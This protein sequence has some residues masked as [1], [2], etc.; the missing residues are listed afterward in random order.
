MSIIKSF[1][2]G[3]GDMFYIFHDSDNLSIIDCCLTDDNR[4]RILKEIIK[5]NNKKGI[6]RF[7]S[8]HPDE[9]HIRGLEYLDDKIGIMNFYA[10]ANRAAKADT[11][12]SFKRYCMLRDHNEKSFKIHNSC[13]RKW[14]NKSDEE[15]GASGID[16][17]W[18]KIENA[19]FQKALKVAEKEGSP[20]N[21]SPIIKYSSH[22]GVRA[23]WMGDM[24][25]EFMSNIEDELLD[26][27]TEIDILFAPHHG[28]N[29]GRV[30]SKILKKMNPK[31]IVIGEG[32]SEDL[33]YYN[34]YKT[35]TQNSYGDIIFECKNSKFCVYSS[36]KRN[37]N[38]IVNSQMLNYNF[39]DT[40]YI[41][42]SLRFI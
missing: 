4:D 2:V 11:T 28:R 13:T 26:I 22:G 40:I 25:T 6:M 23:L 21:I 20:N 3:N 15:R 37:I 18:P 38:S 36:K 35:I 33:N 41:T 32:N 31:I 1:A 10:V 39:I 5:L 8:T 14:M 29:T 9:D 24:E 34:G 27:L 19:E 42:K 30:P 7:I 16:I 17:L 12:E